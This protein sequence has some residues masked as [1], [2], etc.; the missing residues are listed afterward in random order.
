MDEKPLNRQKYC[1]KRSMARFLA[2]QVAYS[3]IF[4]NY[5]SAGYAELNNYIN[6]LSDLFN[7]TEFD[8]QLLDELSNKVLNDSKMKECDSIIE[9]KLHPSW[10]L[11]RLNLI[12]LSVLRVAICEL[13]NFDTPTTV[14]INEYTNIASDLLNKSSEIGFINRLLDMIKK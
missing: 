4:I 14:V 6:F 1:T 12:T 5:F 13:I 8:S 2:V 11:A 3:S 9:T 7:N 10:S